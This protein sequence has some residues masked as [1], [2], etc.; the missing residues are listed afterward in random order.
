MSF[1][2]KFLAAAVLSFAATGSASA[3][4]PQVEKNVSMKMALMIIEGALEQC[5][6]DGYKVSVI[7]VDKAGNVAA[8]VRG[9]GTNPHTM[10]FGRL[11]AYTARTRGQTSLEFKNLTDKPE[12]AYLKQIP[13]VVAVGGGVPIKSG[14]EVIGAVGVS[15][16]PGGEKDEV[17]ANAGIAKVADSLRLLEPAAT[18]IGGSPRRSA[19]PLNPPNTNVPLGHKRTFVATVGLSSSLLRGPSPPLR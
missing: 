18:P 11:K 2:G 19:A 13:N 14:T 9:D 4:A 3:Q 15:G 16:A 6:K 7:V 1:L 17:C 12:S 10:E 5:T 8:S